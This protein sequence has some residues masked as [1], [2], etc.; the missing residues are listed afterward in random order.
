M[1]KAG[2]SVPASEIGEPVKS[3]SSILPAGSKPPRLTPAYGVVEGSIMPVDPEGWPINFRV[4]LPDEVDQTVD[5]NKV[6]VG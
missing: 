4:L 3:L 2:T 5:A 1:V 6:A